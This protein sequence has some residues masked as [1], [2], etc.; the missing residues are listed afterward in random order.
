MKAYQLV[1]ALL[2]AI[3]LTACS[4][5]SN[6]TQ[7]EHA[8]DENLQL[9]AYSNDFEVFAEATPFV[10]GQSSEILAHFSFLKNFKPV[11]EGSITASL[12]VG[13]DGVRQTLEQPTRPGIYK[14]L[15]QPASPGAAKLVFDVRTPE[16]SSQIVVSNIKVYTD[17]HD[18]QHDAAEAA[19]NS[20]SGAVF[21]KEQSWKVDFATEE[22]RSEPLG[23]IIRAT[24]QIQPSQGDERMITAKTGGIVLFSGDNVVE[25][26]AVGAGQ[27]LF[28]I[29]ASGMADNNLSVRL[30]EAESEYN[31]A[32]AEYDRKQELAKDN[33]VSQSD[34][35]KAKTD[36]T[37]AE[38]NYKNLKSNFSAGRQTVS[39]PIGGF[40]TRVLVRNGEFAEAGQ[41]V[42]VVSQNRDLFIKAELQPRYFEVLGNVTTANFRLLN[43][44][45]TY[46]L[47]ELG[48]RLVS[49][50][51]SADLSNPLIP[52]IFQVNNK[53]GLLAGSFVEM[54]IKTQTFVQALTVPNESIVEEMGN[55]F[56]FVQLTPEFFEKRV[57]RK[58]VTDGVRTAITEGVSEGDRVV[59]TGAI[60]V[61]LAQAAG[62][63]DAHSGHVH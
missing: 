48:G 10:V 32:K 43:N 28:S 41:P 46:T 22:A 59:S 3:A 30:A 2:I 16:G 57:V 26:K 50:G 7:D 31:R 61:K 17:V 37:N 56:V 39:S 60:L 4:Q 12:I 47:D 24:G 1:M 34:L 42:L 52:V 25:G 5:K 23:Q 62:A 35:L 27:A 9:T 14:F 21:T 51:K 54:F 63:V 55:Y 38:A 8:H 11:T 18:A 58:G 36:F 44:N 29:D 15:L 6:G 49:Y 20:S 13:T 53:A 40:I 45:R 19:V 33:I